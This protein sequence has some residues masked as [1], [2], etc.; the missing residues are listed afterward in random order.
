MASPQQSC[1]LSSSVRLDRLDATC[2][3]YSTRNRTPT[4]TPSAKI[5]EHLLPVQVFDS[6][7]R[8]PYPVRMAPKISKRQRAILDFIEEQMRDRGLPAVRA[9][10][11][12]C[13][14]AD[15]S[16]DRAQPPEHA[17]ASRLPPARPRQAP[18]DRGALRPEQRRRDGPSPGAIRTTR[19]RRRRR[20]R[21][22]CRRERR[23]TPP[24]PD[25]LRR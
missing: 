1:S 18:S 8:A 9:R 2:V 20:H 4:S 16:V 21:R 14:R 7:V 11:R 17:A 19:R 24:R 6:A 23:R 22:A 12:R 13:R 10:D 5:F 25:R 3:R 15:L